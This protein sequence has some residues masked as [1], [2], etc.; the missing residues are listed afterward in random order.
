MALG[1][2]CQTFGAEFIVSA[3]ASRLRE[4]MRESDPQKGEA[5]GLRG[6]GG[7]LW[8]EPAITKELHPGGSQHL[9]ALLSCGRRITFVANLFG[10]YENSVVIDESGAYLE[11]LP[12]DP[13]GPVRGM[14]WIVEPAKKVTHSPVPISSLIRIDR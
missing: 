12:E 10:V 9:F 6:R 13:V 11:R 8:S 1:L 14:A 7:S 4:F 5:L 2:A 3:S